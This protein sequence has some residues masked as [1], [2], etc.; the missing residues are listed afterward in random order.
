MAIVADPERRVIL[1]TLRGVWIALGDKQC[2]P[3]GQ[4]STLAQIHT[5]LMSGCKNA[6]H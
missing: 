2:C 4:L 5:E 3:A 1:D 6:M